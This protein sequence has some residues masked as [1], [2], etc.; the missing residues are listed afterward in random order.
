MRWARKTPV[1]RLFDWLR[2][3]TAPDPPRYVLITVMN[4][5]QSAPRMWLI[6]QNGVDDLQCCIPTY[7]ASN[8]S[9]VNMVI[10][11]VIQSVLRSMTIR[12]STC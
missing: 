10:I 1:L 6:L 7:S 3:I 4:F 9:Y 2:L 5:F 8:P 12:P 11:G